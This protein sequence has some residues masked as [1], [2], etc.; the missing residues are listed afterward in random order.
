[1]QYYISQPAKVQLQITDVNGRVLYKDISNQ[2]QYG[3]YNAEADISTFAAGT[4]FVSINAGSK[5]YN[6][7]FVKVK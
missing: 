6:K 2:I 4:Y 1:M 3:L 7:Q 5:V